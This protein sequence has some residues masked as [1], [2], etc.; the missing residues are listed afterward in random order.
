[1]K[2]R[3]S[4]G[5]ISTTK[6]ERCPNYHYHYNY[7]TTTEDQE[8]SKWTTRISKDTTWN[9][10]TQKQYWMEPSDTNELK[11]WFLSVGERWGMKDLILIKSNQKK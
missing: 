3:M 6:G 2:H 7:H 5:T 1:M 4:E 8:L 10:F 11:Y 9:K